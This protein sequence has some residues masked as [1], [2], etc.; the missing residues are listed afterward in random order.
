MYVEKWLGGSGI[1]LVV[2]MKRKRISDAAW[3]WKKKVKTI[4]T[5]HIL[6]AIDPYI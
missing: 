3:V 5:H 4:A 1:L 2:T 6:N